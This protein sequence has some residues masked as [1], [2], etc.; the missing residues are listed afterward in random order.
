MHERISVS[1]ISSNGWSFDE[2]VAWWRSA[3]V[4]NVGVA[5][6]KLEA[7]GLAGG[8]VLVVDAGLRVTNLLA[9]A[10]PLTAADRWPAHQERLLAAVA[11]ASAMGAECFVTTTGPAGSMPWDEA[12]DAFAEASAPVVAACR[13]AGIPFVVEHTNSLRADV[14]FVHT[15]RDALDLVRPLGGGVLMEC[16]ACWA[17]RGLAATIAA[18]VEHIRLVQVSDYVIG[19]LCTPD[20]VVPGDGDL[21]LT[22]IIG[23]L[24]DA[25]Y[26]GVFDIE[27]IGP[28]IEAEGYDS[29]IRRSVAAV[30]ALLP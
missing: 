7:F 5:L 1:A 27:L 22:R 18:D 17:E 20:R 6:R 29:A 3:G 9:L 10:F 26:T 21:P 4:T 15:L 14:G 12:A 30:E 16:N 28:R 24:L 8:T 11:A 25:G 2:D 23:W 19:T 13:D